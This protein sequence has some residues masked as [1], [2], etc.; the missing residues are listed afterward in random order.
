MKTAL[1]RMLELLL[2]MSGAKRP[3]QPIAAIAF[4]AHLIRNPESDAGSL[5][6]D[7]R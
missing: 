1:S 4:A 3:I 7:G 6:K 2:A 5:Y